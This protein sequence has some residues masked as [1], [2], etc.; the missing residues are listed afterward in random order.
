MEETKKEETT[1]KEEKVSTENNEPKKVDAEKEVSK[2][3]KKD[4]KVE[5]KTNTAK[6]E[7]KAEKPPKKKMG[8]FKKSIIAIL[9][10]VIVCAIGS[11]IYFLGFAPRTIDLSQYIVLDY[12]GFDGRATATASVNEEALNEYLKDD[13]LAK[14]FADRIEENLSL[15]EYEDL[16]NGDEIEAKVDISSSWLEDNRLKLNS[17]TIKITVEGL[18][19]AGTLDMA[20]YIDVE[21]TGFN[22]YA[23]ATATLDSDSLAKAI[24][25][26]TLA[27]QIV[28]RT[29]LEISDNGTLSNGDKIQ[30]EIS[31]DEDWLEE[32]GY[33]IKSSKITTDEVEGLSEATVLDGFADITVTVSGMSPN[34]KAA[35]TNNSS[36]EFLKTVRYTLSK[37]TG[38]SNG[39]TITITANYN[40]EDAQEQGFVLETDTYEYTVTADVSYPISVSELSTTTIEAMKSTYLEQ[41]RSKANDTKNIVHDNFTDYRVAGENA[42]YSTLG[43]SWSDE[44]ELDITVGEPVLSSMYLLSAKDT[45]DGFNYIYAIY[46]VPFTSKLT[47]VSYDW[48]I[49]VEAQNVSVK[50]DGTLTENAAY[51][52]YT[53]NGTSQETAYSSYINSKKSDYNVETIS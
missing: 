38:I 7:T 51:T 43:Y 22:G 1:S 25:N 42:G 28:N 24:D 6:T 16:S 49:T 52:V 17:D 34:L 44:W 32:N 41:A 26:E 18:E 15:S 19:E 2:E 10:I 5:T 40:K 8:T 29:T 31:I 3:V 50:S 14:K 4:E 20:D 21:Y 46:R 30:I 12:E 33:K 9:I 35:V 23:T 48:Y 11:L 45:S 53:D 39:E 37:S 13:D 36:N 27:S 47:G